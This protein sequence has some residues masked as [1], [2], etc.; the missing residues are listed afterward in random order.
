MRNML[1]SIAWFL[2]GHSFSLVN[3]TKPFKRRRDTAIVIMKVLHLILIMLSSAASVLAQPDPNY[4]AHGLY[5]P[6]IVQVLPIIGTVPGGVK[7][8]D[9]YS[10]S[11]NC[12]CIPNP[13]MAMALMTT[14][15]RPR[16]AG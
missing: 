10:I 3:H 12:Y 4:L 13:F 1:V 11:N 16:G 2:L 9:S 5:H 8:A 6:D 15:W 14:R 7:W